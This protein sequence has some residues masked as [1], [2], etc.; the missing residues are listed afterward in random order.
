M[1]AGGKGEWAGGKTAGRGTSRGSVFGGK[2]IN[3]RRF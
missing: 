3:N 1:R 2:I